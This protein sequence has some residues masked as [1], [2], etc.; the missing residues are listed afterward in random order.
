MIEKVTDDN[1]DDDEPTTAMMLLL[2]IFPLVFFCSS[3]LS[4]QHICPHSEVCLSGCSSLLYLLLF[5]QS[6]YLAVLSGSRKGTGPATVGEQKS[7]T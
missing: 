4:V 6:L 7:A 3:D 5:S 1:D 2:L